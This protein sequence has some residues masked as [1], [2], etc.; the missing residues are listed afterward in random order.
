MSLKSG[1]RNVTEQTFI[2]VNA[3][4][5]EIPDGVYFV[6]LTKIGDPRTVTA[7]QGPRQGED[8]DLIDWTFTIEQPGS[9]LHEQVIDASTSTASGPRSKMYAWLTAL[10]GG[11]APIVGTNFKKSDLI[12]RYAL[13]TTRK[14]DAGWPKIENLG[15]APAALLAT[16]IAAATGTAVQAPGSPAPSA[17][18]PAPLREAVAAGDLPF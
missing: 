17:A 2:T 6:Q 10:L 15:A 4:G 12:G 3:G 13:A 8:V 16:R 11:V 9:E 14:N 7:Q 18:Q 5:P 1:E